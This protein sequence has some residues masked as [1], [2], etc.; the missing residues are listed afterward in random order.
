MGG[1]SFS[2]AVLVDDHQ[3]VTDALRT[4]VPAMRDFARIETATTL[5]DACALLEADPDCQLV[6][7]DL[8]LPDSQGRETLLGLRERFPE[9]PILVYSGDA[10]LGAIIMAFDCG[11]HG[12]VTK[13]SP[14]N[15]IDE[16][17][18]EVLAGGF[19]IPPEA[20]RDL[21]WPRGS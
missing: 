21:G 10:T 17:I 2:R 19:Y 7:L 16:A 13:N 12:Y 6:V 5:A 18:R 4:C 8:H 11:A 15:V 20:A 1:A 3:I 9:V 14:M